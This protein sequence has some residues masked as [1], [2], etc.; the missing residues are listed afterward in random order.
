MC[1]LEDRDLRKLGNSR[2]SFRCP[3]SV[4]RL[5]LNP[6]C[7]VVVFGT[8]QIGLRKTREIEGV[9][10]RK[11]E[12]YS[13]ER[14]SPLLLMLIEA[15]HVLSKIPKLGIQVAK[16]GSRT[17]SARSND[18]V[19][20]FVILSLESQVGRCIPQTE[21]QLQGELVWAQSA[22]LL[23]FFPPLSESLALTLLRHPLWHSLRTVGYLQAVCQFLFKVS[24][25]RAGNA[26]V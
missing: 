23:T 18:L 22:P 9:V 11:H 13:S 16:E 7:N 19:Q 6:F 5:S 21:Q 25:S 1:L 2:W 3:I 12:G 10:T 15:F 20:P 17:F 26:R 4:G 8:I 14:I 24:S